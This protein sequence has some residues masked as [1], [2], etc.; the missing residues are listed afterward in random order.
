MKCLKDVL[1]LFALGNRVVVLGCVWLQ[2]DLSVLHVGNSRVSPGKYN[3]WSQHTLPWCETPGSPV[4]GTSLLHTVGRAWAAGDA[5]D[6]VSLLF[7]DPGSASQHQ[8]MLMAL[9]FTLYHIKYCRLS[10]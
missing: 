8:E 10:E 3:R 5:V 6:A 9:F 1:W 2:R 7:V 4:Q